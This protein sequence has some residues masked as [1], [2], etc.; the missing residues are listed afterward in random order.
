MGKFECWCV[1][2]GD[3]V[4]REYFTR[5]YFTREYAAR[6]H[7]EKSLRNGANVRLIHMIEA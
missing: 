7:L 4:R 1:I 2:F 5:E 3:D 6:V